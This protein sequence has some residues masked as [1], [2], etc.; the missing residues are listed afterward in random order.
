[1]EL[2]CHARTNSDDSYVD[3]RK[4]LPET[5]PDSNLTRCSS[6]VATTGQLPLTPFYLRPAQTDYG[7]MRTHRVLLQTISTISISLLTLC[8]LT[9]AL[10]DWDLM[11]PNEPTTQD[12]MNPDSVDPW[13]P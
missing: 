9:A 2:P 3:A 11:N 8:V 13:A 4:P 12:L 10:K 6:C 5:D 7:S 1:M